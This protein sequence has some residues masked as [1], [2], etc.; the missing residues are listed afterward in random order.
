M[1]GQFVS[2]LSK[3][4]RP[5]ALHPYSFNCV[6]IF[7]FLLLNTISFAQ[8]AVIPDTLQ[9]HRVMLIPYDPRY[10]LSDAD[11]DIIEQS[12]IAPD[13]IRSDFRHN[14]DYNVQRSISGSYHCISLL[15]D[16]MQ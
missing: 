12:K 3:L 6:L 5:D 14:I 10:Y 13:K 4:Y 16:T 7:L 9:A 2:F 11:R 15:N 1:P 8:E